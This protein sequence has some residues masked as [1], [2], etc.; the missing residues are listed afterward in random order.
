MYTGQLCYLTVMEK[1]A[2]NLYSWEYNFTAALYGRLK[3][4]HQ[5]R[6]IQLNLFF[7]EVEGGVISLNG[8]PRHQYIRQWKRLSID[9]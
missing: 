3:V 1:T 7:Q 6:G 9:I 2:V 4:T 5:C 8:F